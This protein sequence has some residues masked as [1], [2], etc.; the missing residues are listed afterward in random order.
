MTLELG[1]HVADIA[2][3]LG[4]K[5]SP[6]EIED[7]LRKYV[8]YGVPLAQA[9]RDIIRNHGGTVRAG[10][11]TLAELVGGENAVD[12]LV[13]VQ[14]VNE[15]EI[16]TKEG[17]KKV[18]YGFLA[19]ET[20]GLAYTAWK[21]FSL[22]K[23]RVYEIKG[24]YVKT[25]REQPDVN[26]GD[27]TQ[28]VASTA[29][30]NA[31]E[32]FAR[33]SASNAPSRPGQVV[34]IRELREGLSNVTVTGRIV[35]VE[36]RQITVQG[37]P[38]TILKGVLADA[39]GRIPF[40]AWTPTPA[41]AAGAAVRILG[42]YVKAFRGAPD[43]NLGDSAR[44]EPAGDVPAESDL[45][46]ARHATIAEVEKAGG[47]VEVEGVVLEVKPGSGLVFRCPECNRVLQK[48]ECRLH[49]RVEGIADL[50]TKAVLD[51]G[52]GALTLLIGKEGTEKLLGRTFEDCQRIAK[53]AMSTEVVED[54]LKQKILARRLVAR[55]NATKDEFGVQLIAT[56]A[57]LAGP[58]DGKAEAEKI[59]EELADLGVTA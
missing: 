32:G 14:T 55:G 2:R 12:L 17:A 29:Q 51:D 41:L 28:I 18:W 15:K 27:R 58:K 34:E 16:Q 30:I 1:P 54:E 52:H 56:Q 37:A 10:R 35:E 46:L 24:A 57:E 20:K 53:D 45:A 11:R 39:T 43:L 31:V 50:R 19:D 25:F 4:N 40:T 5:L 36:E 59:L 8:D 6:D 47:I 49:G 42:G 22:E 26:L 38:R 3:A 7:E 13:K 23:G 33:P 44:V 48:R 9:K 21:D